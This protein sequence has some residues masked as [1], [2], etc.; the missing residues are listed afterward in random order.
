[1][2][3]VLARAYGRWSRIKDDAPDAYLRAMLATTFLTWWHRRW[4]AETPT[5]HLP[6]PSTPDEAD[7][8]EL[9]RMVRDAILTLPYQQRAVLMLRFHADLTEQA[10]AD[11][12][13]ISLGTVKS[14]TARALGA[15][16]R[17]LRERAGS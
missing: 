5:E 15:M 1:V 7:R 6:E 4:R 2:Q 14:Y 11:A 3:T 8:I 9:R 13:G 17:L 16:R 10:T 12:L